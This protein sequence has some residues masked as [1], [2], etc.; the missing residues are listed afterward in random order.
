MSQSKQA[1]WQKNT[2]LNE[3]FSSR[4]HVESA[5]KIFDRVRGI[6]MPRKSD[7]TP[8]FMEDQPSKD[9]YFPA[10][11]TEI[12]EVLGKIPKTDTAGITHIWLRRAKASEF[13]S[14][15]I[16]FAEYVTRDDIHL[17]VLYPWPENMIFPLTKKPA[18]AVLTRYKKWAPEPFSHKGKWN[19]KWNATT[20]QDFYL[21]ELLV[22]E[23]GHHVDFQQK[24][25]SKQNGM[26][27]QYAT[28]RYF[29]ET[30]IIY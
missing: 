14:G 19:L 18:D 30:L 11:V 26:P 1:R 4:A 3:V 16:P 2:E 6:Q 24:N 13:R 23:I 5:D 12:T 22:R 28:Q 8:L 29:E 25:W 27:V 10:S 17:I 21:H 15:R 7:V 20:V 9:A